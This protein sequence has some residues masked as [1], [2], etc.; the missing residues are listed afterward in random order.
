MHQKLVDTLSKVDVQKKFAP[1]IFKRGVL[2][3][4]LRVLSAY[5][6]GLQRF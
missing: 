3:H 5:R 4:I 1:E 6:R 2:A